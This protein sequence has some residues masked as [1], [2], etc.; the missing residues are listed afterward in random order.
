VLRS[1]A[2]KD[3]IQKYLI[4]FPS[5][6]PEEL[7]DL[8]KIKEYWEINPCS[9]QEL[10]TLLEREESVISSSGEMKCRNE[11]ENAMAVK[12][13]KDDC[14]WDEIAYEMGNETEREVDNYDS[15]TDKDSDGNEVGEGHG[16][17]SEHCRVST[18]RLISISPDSTDV[19][20]GYGS[21]SDYSDYLVE[22]FSQDDDPD[23][24]PPDFAVASDSSEPPPLLNS[25]DDDTDDD[26]DDLPS[27]FS[28][29]LEY[30]FHNF[31]EQNRRHSFQR[32]PMPPDLRYDYQ[33][34]RFLPD[35][36]GNFQSKK[37]RPDLDP[38]SLMEKRRKKECSDIKKAAKLAAKLAGSTRGA[39]KIKKENVTTA[40][41]ITTRA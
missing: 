7:I 28:G 5:C 3:S 29:E 13:K 26:I 40:C 32:K 22:P 17:F 16:N 35:L 14:A 20:Y 12:A 30:H 18:L 9:P 2:Y 39:K 24:E 31:N 1:S 38:V 21:G 11:E 19:F 27:L 15:D 33:A 34:E 10:I 36:Q 37:A 8:L 6:T 23:D 4:C 25:T 41:A